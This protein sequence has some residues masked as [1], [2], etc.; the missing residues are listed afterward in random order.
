M[1]QRSKR[2]NDAFQAAFYALEMNLI[3]PATRRSAIAVGKMIHDDFVEFGSSGDR[4]DRGHAIE[5]MT[6]GLA[7]EV[8][9]KDFEALTLAPSVVLCT[10]RS[11]GETGREARRS[12]IWVESDNEWKIIFHQGTRVPDSWMDRSGR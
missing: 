2:D 1:E 12:S 5:V 4:Y 8:L 3:D 10:Y 11:I 9:I 6:S 7:G